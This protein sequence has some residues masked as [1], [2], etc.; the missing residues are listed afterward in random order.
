MLTVPVGDP[1]PGAFTVTVAV[2]VTDWPKTDGFVPDASVVVVDALFTTWLTAA[3]V[4]VAKLA[5][6]M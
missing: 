1:A 5:S 2:K 4:L 6:P 3:L